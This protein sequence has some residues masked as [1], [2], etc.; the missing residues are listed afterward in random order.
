[1]IDL[2]STIWPYKHIIFTVQKHCIALTISQKAKSTSIMLDD[3]NGM[4]WIFD[5]NEEKS[6][7]TL[8]AYTRS[9]YWS[10][11]VMEIVYTTSL[12]ASKSWSSITGVRRGNMQND[13]LTL[14]ISNNPIFTL[15]LFYRDVV[16][17][18]ATALHC[19]STP[20]DAGFCCIIK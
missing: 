7:G 17:K 15:V 9:D 13:M 14:V 19:T 18:H 5:F 20:I 8:H 4:T 11:R 12:I 2:K 10:S 3:K 6:N 16:K 1:M